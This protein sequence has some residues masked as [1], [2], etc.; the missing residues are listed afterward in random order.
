MQGY[1]FARPLS[2]ESCT[3]LLMGRRRM[4][5]VKPRIASQSTVRIF[6]L[7][8]RVSRRQLAEKAK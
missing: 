4:H 6:D 1:L 7:A 2:V 8:S 3:R 5:F